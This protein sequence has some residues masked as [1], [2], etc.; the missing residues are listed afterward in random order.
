MFRGL[1]FGGGGGGGGGGRPKIELYRMEKW[2]YFGLD[3]ENGERKLE[4]TV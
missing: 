4:A 2:S 3:G 1:G